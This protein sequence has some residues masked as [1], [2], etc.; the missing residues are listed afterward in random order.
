MT[1][2][3]K[4]VSPGTLTSGDAGGWACPSAVEVRRRDENSTG[5]GVSHGQALACSCAPGFRT[6]GGVS[7][8]LKRE[9]L[10]QLPAGG[11][12]QREATALPTHYPFSSI[13]SGLLLCSLFALTRKV[14]TVLPSMGSTAPSPLLLSCTEN[15]RYTKGN[16]SDQ[17]HAYGAS[18]PPAFPAYSPQGPTLHMSAE[19]L[20]RT[21]WGMPGY[22]CAKHI[23]VQH[24]LH[25]QIFTSYD[26]S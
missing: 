9:G 16:G 5:V 8:S 19:P 14:H 23:C 11:T 24:T 25:S 13:L 3:F 26:C 20:H 1:S 22:F 17:N 15:L 7:V 18:S 6:A 4:P 21:E 12:G 10:T 2:H